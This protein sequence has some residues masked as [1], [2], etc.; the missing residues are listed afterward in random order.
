MMEITNI[1]VFYLLTVMSEGNDDTKFLELIEPRFIFFVPIWISIFSRDNVVKKIRLVIL[2]NLVNCIY[3]Y[4]I[5][6]RI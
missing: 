4:Y 1:I 2:I 6:A 3:K 5:F